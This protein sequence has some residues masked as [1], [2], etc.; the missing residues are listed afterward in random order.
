[1]SSRVIVCCMV[2]A[3]AGMAGKNDVGRKRTSDMLHA[4]A[5]PRACVV[6]S[7]PGAR[8]TARYTQSQCWRAIDLSEPQ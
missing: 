7:A 8:G 4:A 1:M 3:S 2:A 5:R 6:R